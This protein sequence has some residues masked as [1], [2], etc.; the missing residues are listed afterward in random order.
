MITMKIARMFQTDALLRARPS[1]SLMGTTVDKHAGHAMSELGPER[2]V[3]AL[4]PQV[5]GDSKWTVALSS[6]LHLQET[7]VKAHFSLNSL[8]NQ[9]SS[10][11][12]CKSEFS[13]LFWKSLFSHWCVMEPR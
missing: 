3:V 12:R 2:V 13:L 9:G 6:C 11:K 7:F 8:A 4:P 5:V 10:A 1:G